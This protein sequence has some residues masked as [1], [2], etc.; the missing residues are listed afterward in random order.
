[1]KARGV[2]IGDERAILWINFRGAVVEQ[3]FEGSN[4]PDHFSIIECRDSL[5]AAVVRFSTNFYINNWF[6][7][8]EPHLWNWPD[9]DYFYS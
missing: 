1:L 9:V 7:G 6:V 2:G 8:F 5:S 4:G 3:I